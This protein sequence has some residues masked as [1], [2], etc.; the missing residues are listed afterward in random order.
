MYCNSTIYLIYQNYYIKVDNT[1]DIIYG[2]TEKSII[3]QT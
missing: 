3:E 2:W 1:I